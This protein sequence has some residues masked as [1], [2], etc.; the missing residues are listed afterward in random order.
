MTE[1]RRPETGFA[2]VSGTKLYY[3][4][5]LDFRDTSRARSKKSNAPGA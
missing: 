5:S 3:E 2:V 4:E 1:A